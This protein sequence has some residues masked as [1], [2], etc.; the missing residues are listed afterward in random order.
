MATSFICGGVLVSPS[1]AITAK[2]CVS[3]MSASDLTV[4]VGLTPATQTNITVDSIVS[5]SSFNYT[6]LENDVAILRLSSPTTSTPYAVLASPNST[7]LTFSRSRRSSPRPTLSRNKSP[8][9]YRPAFLNSSLT[10][11]GWGPPTSNTQSLSPH[12]LS[13]PVSLIPTSSCAQTLAECHFPLDPVQRLCTSST[14]Q[15]MAAYGDA[16]GPVVDEQGTVVALITGNP[17]CAQPNGIGIKL[18]LDGKGVG[19]WLAGV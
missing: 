8:L 17:R 4:R 6:S 11:Y 12:L 15:G 7:T 16:G 2:E 13:A 1:V 10:I 3:G 5:M 14:T 19:G 18:R 9:T